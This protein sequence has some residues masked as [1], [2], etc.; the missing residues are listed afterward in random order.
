MNSTKWSLVFG[1]TLI[2]S[3]AGCSNPQDANEANFKVSIQAYLDAT[4][5]KCV[6]K[7]ELPVEL[8]VAKWGNVAALTA[9]AD[10]GLLTMSVEKK[11]IKSRWGSSAKGDV[12]TFMLSDQGKEYFTVTQSAQ[13]DSAMEGGFCIGKADDVIIDQ[14]TQPTDMMGHTISRVKY[15]YQLTDIPSWALDPE[16]NKHIRDVRHIVGTSGER[17]KA[18]AVLI[19]TNKGWVHEKLFNK[20]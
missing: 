20:R 19:L 17:P 7:T 9:L 14:F 2:T 6:V 1:C 4:F 8:P 5:P 16:V 3:L 13:G 11:E 18:D 15:D 10:V 12:A